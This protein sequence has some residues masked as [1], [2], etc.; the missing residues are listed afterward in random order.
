MNI[1]KQFKKKSKVL[2]RIVTCFQT[3]ILTPRILKVSH[4]YDAEQQ[5]KL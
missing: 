1:L 2:A 5:S 4:L 3:L